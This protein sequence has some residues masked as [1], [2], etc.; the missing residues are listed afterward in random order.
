MERLLYLLWHQG[1]LLSF[2][3]QSHTSFTNI[4]V[5]CRHQLCMHVRWW[6]R[7]R[8]RECMLLKKSFRIIIF[9]GLFRNPI[10]IVLSEYLRTPLGRRD[11]G[12]RLTLIIRATS[13]G[14]IWCQQKYDCLVLCLWKSSLWRCFPKLW[15][16]SRNCRKFSVVMYTCYS[17][18]SY[19]FF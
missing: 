7:D 1:I 19:S 18:Y 12:L 15:L 4:K 5:P 9:W 8:R 16:S 3:N 14:R 6:K 13:Y 10:I 2:S 17:T 11:K